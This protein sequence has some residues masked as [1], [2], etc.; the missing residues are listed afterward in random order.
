[1]KNNGTTRTNGT[2][3]IMKDVVAEGQIISNDQYGWFP[4]NVQATVL[5]REGQGVTANL[6]EGSIHENGADNH[7]VT[8]FG[9]FL[10]GSLE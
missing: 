6:I 2:T 3:K 10:I 8:A 7:L 4:L 5:L 1:M 9:G